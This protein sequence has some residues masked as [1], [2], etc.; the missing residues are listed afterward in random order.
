MGRIHEYAAGDLVPRACFESDGPGTT[1]EIKRLRVPDRA[2]RRNTPDG[3]DRRRGNQI[4]AYRLKA[5]RW[6]TPADHS[7]DNL[8]S[9]FLIRNDA[10]KFGDV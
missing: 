5:L 1:R 7:I 9:Q 2:E 3:K 4:H 10:S 6:Y 8:F